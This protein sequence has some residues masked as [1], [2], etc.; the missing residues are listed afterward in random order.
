[1]KQKYTC[2][3]PKYKHKILDGKTTRMLKPTDLY[4]FTKP[5]SK[6]SDE[7]W[8]VGGDIDIPWESMSHNGW[9]FIRRIS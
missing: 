2:T 9:V 6:G 4:N 3:F 7:W 5:V 1:M 8:T